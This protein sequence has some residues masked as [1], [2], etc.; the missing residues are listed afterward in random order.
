MPAA[1]LMLAIPVVLA[2]SGRDAGNYVTLFGPGTTPE[3]AFAAIAEAGPS[4]RVAGLGATWPLTALRVAAAPGG[5]ADPAALRQADGA[6]LVL[7]IPALPECGPGTAS[8]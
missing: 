3:A 8:P 4:W 2:C 5:A 1:L 7:P 6:W